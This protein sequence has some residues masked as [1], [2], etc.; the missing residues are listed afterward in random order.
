MQE[1][2]REEVRQI[3]VTILQEN[4]QHISDE[5]AP[6]HMKTWDSL[7]NVKI[8]SDIEKS[9]NIRFKLH[10]I[11]SFNNVGAICDCVEKYVK[12]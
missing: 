12:S 6:Q 10:D 5:T 9:F 3:I 7:N 2:V 11:F 1:N 4:A 8:I